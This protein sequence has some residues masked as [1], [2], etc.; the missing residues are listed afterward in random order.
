MPTETS[1]ETGKGPAMMQPVAA[2]AAHVNAVRRVEGVL[3]ARRGT[4][5]AS[6]K[7][8]FDVTGIG[9][10]SMALYRAGVARW[11]EGNS[12]TILGIDVTQSARNLIASRRPS[13]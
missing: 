7:I 6:H 8:M 12:D 10:L 1:P 4:Y 3:R 9:T 13:S 5:V 11:Y 2:S